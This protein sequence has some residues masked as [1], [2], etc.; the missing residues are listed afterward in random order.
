MRGVTI[1][2]RV[3]SSSDGSADRGTP[4]YRDCSGSEGV[5]WSPLLCRSSSIE[6]QNARRIHY[7]W[8]ASHQSQACGRPTECSKMVPR[9][10]SYFADL[11]GRIGTLAC[12]SFSESTVRPLGIDVEFIR[13]SIG[14]GGCAS[15][16]STV[17]G[18]LESDLVKGR[19][20]RRSVGIRHPKAKNS[21]FQRVYGRFGI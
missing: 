21:F 13:E 5:A 2:W 6:W 11:R 1:C 20:A 17:V 16:G 4:P 12:S 10:W 3:G 9:S 15:V 8:S 7:S 18:F 19:P 14:G